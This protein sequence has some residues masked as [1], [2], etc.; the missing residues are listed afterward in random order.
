MCLRLAESLHYKLKIEISLIYI[1][2]IM[3]YFTSHGRMIEFQWSH[4]DLCDNSLISF[5]FSF[6]LLWGRIYTY[7]TAYTILY[8]S[9]TKHMDCRLHYSSLLRRILLMIGT[10]T[11][12][13]FFISLFIFRLENTPLWDIFSLL[14]FAYLCEKKPHVSWGVQLLDLCGSLQ[15]LDVRGRTNVVSFNVL[16][17]S[18]S[19]TQNASPSSK[20]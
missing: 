10:L 4:L 14:E 16:L 5:G 18:A 12:V 17:P 3:F 15:F 20:I 8:T 2:P 9:F 11:W 7:I 13:I 1:Y 6:W 19:A